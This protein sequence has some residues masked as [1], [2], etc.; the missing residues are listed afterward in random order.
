MFE[1]A[2][3]LLGFKAQEEQDLTFSQEEDAYWGN[4]DVLNSVDEIVHAVQKRT[5]LNDIPSF[6][7][8]LTQEEQTHGW[9][10]VNAVAREYGDGEQRQ[11]GDAVEVNVDGCEAEVGEEIPRAAERPQQIRT[12]IPAQVMRVTPDQAPPRS[13]SEPP[14]K[15]KQRTR[16]N[17]QWWNTP[18]FGP[19]SPS[20]L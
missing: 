2:R 3:Q 4:P 9:D 14:Q 19:D 8:G 18:H 20:Q 15:S 7:L 17:D 11:E 13:S 1:S 6:S 16:E 10:D 5:Y 12:E